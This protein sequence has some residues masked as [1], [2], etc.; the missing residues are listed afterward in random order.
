MLWHPGKQTHVSQTNKRNICT[1]CI[2]YFRTCKHKIKETVPTRKGRPCINDILWQQWSLSLSSYLQ[3]N[4]IIFRKGDDTNNSKETQL[5]EAHIPLPPTHLSK[6]RFSVHCRAP[7]VCIRKQTYCI[8]LEPS[9]ETYAVVIYS[10]FQ[11]QET[12]PTTSFASEI[13]VRVSLVFALT[14][15]PSKDA[16]ISRYTVHAIAKCS[17]YMPNK[18]QTFIPTKITR[19]L[20]RYPII[21]TLC[22][23]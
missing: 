10:R 15:L 3:L 14:A 8:A 16:N 4:D 12:T 11:C 1:K 18:T 2:L 20:L 9:E 23:K 21:L 13:P 19:Y 7:S 6:Y 22:G 17:R 5:N